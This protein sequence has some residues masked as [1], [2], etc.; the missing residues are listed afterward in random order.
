VYPQEPNQE[1]DQPSFTKA[2]PQHKMV[3][4]MKTII[5]RMTTI[6]GETKMIN[7]RRIM[8]KMTKNN[9]LKHLKCHTQESTKTYNEITRG[10][11]TWRYSKGTMTRSRIAHFCENYSFAPYLAPFKIEYDLRDPD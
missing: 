4:K 3:I 8:K 5:K 7:R 2:S 1:H 11:D 9:M 6:K 10:H